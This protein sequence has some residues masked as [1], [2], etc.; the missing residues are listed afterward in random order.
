MSKAENIKNIIIKFMVSGNLLK[1]MDFSHTQINIEKLK[2]IKFRQNKKLNTP[3]IKDVYYKKLTTF[4]DERGDLTELWS[5]PWSLNEPIAPE[6]KHVYYNTTHE[7][8]VKGWHFHEKTYSQYTCVK[9]MMQVCLL[10]IRDTSKTFGFVDI[11]MIGTENPSFIKIPPGVLKAWK[12]IKGDSV[13]VNLLTTAQK[14]DNYKFDWDIIL[15]DIW[16]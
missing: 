14:E 1:I 13:I 8:F 11:F 4:K 2:K 16:K 7:G 12:S 3:K 6:V 10:D 15:R 9:G 5:F